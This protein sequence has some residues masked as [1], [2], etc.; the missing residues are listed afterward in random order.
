MKPHTPSIAWLYEE[1][2]EM[3]TLKT[4]RIGLALLMTAVAGSALAAEPGATEADLLRGPKVVDASGPDG[5]DTMDGSAVESQRAG[6][7]PFQA[8]LGAVRGLNKAAKENPELALTDEQKESI[9]EIG[10][11]YQAEMKAFRDEHKEEFGAMRERGGERGEQGKRGARDQKGKDVAERGERAERGDKGDEM[12][13]R[14]SPEEMQRMREKMAELR[15]QAP[16]GQE[17]KKQLW[18][19]LTPAQQDAVQEQVESIRAKRHEKVDKAMKRG[20]TEH[21][22]GRTAEG[23]DKGKKRTQGRKALS[24]DRG[25]RPERKPRDDD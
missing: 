24:K 21:A 15:A 25:D 16:S 14:P 13:E 19:V 4:Q 5:G 1:V 11:E 9:K 7:M 8:Y 17:S 6:D 18:A 12:K 22:D 10:R 23:D 2:L 3:N 20:D